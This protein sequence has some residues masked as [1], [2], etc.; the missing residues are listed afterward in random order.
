M[1]RVDVAYDVADQHLDGHVSILKRSGAE[2]FVFAGLP[3]NAA[4]VIRIAGEHNWRPVFILNQMASS[5]GTALKPAG[6]E[7][8]IGLITAGF[9]KDASDP[10][11]KDEPFLKDWSKFIDKYTKAGGKDDGAAAYGYAAAETLA[12]VLRQCGNDLSRE[13]V[14]EA[15]GGTQGV[16]G[17]SRAAGNQDQHRPFGFPADQATAT[18]TVRWPHMAVD[19]R[20][21]RNR[22]LDDGKREVA[23]AAWGRPISAWLAFPVQIRCH[24]N[25][26][27][28][29]RRQRRSPLWASTTVGQA[30]A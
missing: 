30:G 29:R 14:M 3:E 24:P 28:R 1:I 23:Y 21:V 15:G 18:D 19:R 26:A 12:Q 16:S 4:K 7:N 25:A 9:L 2:I 5:I 11:W 20:R 13:N 22:L 17:L 27:R 8:A 10:A 6:L